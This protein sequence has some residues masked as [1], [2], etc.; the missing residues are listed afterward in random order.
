MDI[1]K[2]GAIWSVRTPVHTYAWGGGEKGS[3]IEIS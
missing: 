1:W 2:C 3:L